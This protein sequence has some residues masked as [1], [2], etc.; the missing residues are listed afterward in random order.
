[1]HD[2]IPAL[3]GVSFFRDLSRPA[4]EAVAAR[5][6]FRSLPA[7]RLLF[8]AG[9]P[10]RGAHI[11]VAGRVEIY[12]ATADGREQT[13]H[14]ES[15]VE[16]I[17]ELPLFDGGEYPA[18][19]RTTEPSELYFLSLDDF[20]RLYREHPEIADAVIRNLGRRLRSL[21][22]L[23]E[24][25]SLKSVPGRVAATLLEMAGR[26]A[27]RVDGGSFTLRRTQAEL[28]L[29]LA[30]SRESVARALAE[31]RKNGWIEQEGPSVTIR[32]VIALERA[33]ETAP[34]R[35]SGAKPQPFGAPV[36]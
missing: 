27:A 26:S 6:V 5:M 16:S 18:S 20:Q 21:V 10:S 3:E 25:V 7:G 4:L 32:S 2:P 17:A 34:H 31:F 28:A 33:A 11:L 30:T 15:P 36:E 35:V 23:V 24:K 12:R 13:L 8:K 1:V 29:E 9:D 19:A 14:A 22:K